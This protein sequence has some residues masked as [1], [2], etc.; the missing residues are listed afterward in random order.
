MAVNVSKT[1]YIIFH[2]RGKQINLNGLNV[3]FN[4]KDP[5]QRF[6]DPLLIQPLER[7]HD[8]NPNEKRGVLNYLVFTLLSN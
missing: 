6:S 5:D 2:T 3:V 7:I 4:S 1:N 8:N